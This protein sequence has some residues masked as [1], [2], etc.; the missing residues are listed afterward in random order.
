MNYPNGQRNAYIQIHNVEYE[1]ASVMCMYFLNRLECLH[2]NH[3]KHTKTLL[4]SYI[5]ATQT[6]GEISYTKA[7]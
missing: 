7:L 3:H 5:K 4:A 6:K 2:S 1:F